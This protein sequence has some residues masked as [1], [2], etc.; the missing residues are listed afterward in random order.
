MKIFCSGLI[1][2]SFM[3]WE[4]RLSQCVG[5]IS[6]NEQELGSW[7]WP[8]ILKIFWF[9]KNVGRDHSASL[10]T[11]ITYRE[12]SCARPHHSLYLYLTSA[13][14]SALAWLSV[15]NFSWWIDESLLVNHSPLSF[16]FFPPSSLKCPGRL[17]WV[18]ALS[19][20]VFC[21]FWKTVGHK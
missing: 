16:F 1:P 10:P 11:S 12:N 13:S 3:L 5:N 17:L 14:L 7:D 21:F 8:G 9:M 20:L 2:S 18:P 6:Y 19:G 15:L 4:P